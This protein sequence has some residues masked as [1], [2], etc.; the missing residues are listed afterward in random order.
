[1]VDISVSPTAGALA[2]RRILIVEDEYFIAAEIR[3]MLEEHG[4]DVIG[5]VA[6]IRKANIAIASGGRI[7]CA[8]LDIDVNGQ[9]VFPVIPL[10]REQGIPWIYVS[11]FSE[12]LVP[13]HLRA[14]AHLEKP[15]DE[16]LL[17]DAV[18]SVGR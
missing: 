8:I 14:R 6:D 15:V 7:D 3:L 13:V 11:G 16:K 4:A 12:P 5:P 18:M 10:L 9:A 1:M 17:V 2:G